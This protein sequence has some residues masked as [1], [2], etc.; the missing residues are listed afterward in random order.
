MIT[1]KINAE[2]CL[3]PLM[4]QNFPVRDRVVVIIDI[5]RATSCWVT[6]LANGAASIR[7]VITLDECKSLMASGY[8]GAAERQG[9]KMEGFDLGNSPFE[10]SAEKVKGK[11]IAIT[12]TNGTG[13]INSFSAS[14][15]VVIGSF[16]NFSGVTKYL[17]NSDKNIVLACSGWEGGISL[18]DTLFA[19]AVLESLDPQVVFEGDAALMAADLW[20]SSQPY[21]R[22]WLKKSSHVNRLLNLGLEKDIEYCLI[23]DLFNIVPR[24]SGLDIIK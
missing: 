7:P 10:Y 23:I 21:F 6:A 3:S 14:E 11:D 16:L 13:N 24:L 5:L 22:N 20:K 2:V 18:E 9:K 8:I 12:T 15:D 4:A 17:K 1:G 19:G